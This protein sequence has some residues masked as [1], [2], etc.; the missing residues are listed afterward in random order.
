[1]P[2]L[3]CCPKERIPTAG[4]PLRIIRIRLPFQLGIFSFCLQCKTIQ[5]KKFADFEISFRGLTKFHEIE[6]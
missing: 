4:K 1:M 5:T 6:F 2:D 3:Q